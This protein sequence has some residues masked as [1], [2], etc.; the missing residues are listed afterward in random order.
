ME[1]FIIYHVPGVKIGCTEKGALRV[2]QQGYDYFEVLETH[3]NVYEASTREQELQRQ[4][5]Y[6]VDACPYHKTYEFT[7]RPKTAET[8]ER[9]RIAQI[10]NTN[11]R[12]TVTSED[13]KVKIG[14][15]NRG[16]KH[17]EEVKIKIG[18]AQRR[19]KPKVECPHCGKIGGNSL[20][21]RYHFDN[22]KHIK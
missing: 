18:A 1:Q 10:G 12:G 9:C 15:A 20:M 11:K 6:P 8:K 19:P 21:T 7:K 2:K 14:N 13:T 3:N 4:Y 17:T 16:N 22:C 5:G